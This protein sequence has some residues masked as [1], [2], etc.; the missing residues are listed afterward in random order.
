MGPVRET[1]AVSSAARGGPSDGTLANAQ[2]I[3][4]SPIDLGNRISQ[5]AVYGNIPLQ[6]AVGDAFV[7]ERGVGVQLVSSSGVVASV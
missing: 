4:G 6:P 5:S 2:Q 1:A 7:S 3:D